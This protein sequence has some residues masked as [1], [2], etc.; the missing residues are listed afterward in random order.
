MQVVSIV[1]RTHDMLCH[2]HIKA[3]DKVSSMFVSWRSLSLRCDSAFLGQK[4]A[5]L[6]PT[7]NKLP[8]VV[9]PLGKWLEGKHVAIMTEN[10]HTQLHTHCIPCPT[11]SPPTFVALLADVKNVNEFCKIQFQCRIVGWRENSPHALG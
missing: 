1:H 9:V 6:A 4:W 11:Q 2:G 7:D 3:W 10:H 8:M 5:L